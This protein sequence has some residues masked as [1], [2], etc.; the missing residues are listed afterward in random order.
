MA[1]ALMVVRDWKPAVADVATL[2]ADFKLAASDI[3]A[4]FGII[5]ERAKGAV[6]GYSAMIE[7][8]QVDRLKQDYPG[9]F[10]GPYG[11]VQAAP[12]GKPQI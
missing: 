6:T 11:G 12:F 4:D 10:D 3:D 9:Q 8:T 7:E 1:F 5:A 2:A